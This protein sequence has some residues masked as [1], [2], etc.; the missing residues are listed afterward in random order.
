[1]K[2]TGIVFIALFVISVALTWPRYQFYRVTGKWFPVDKIEKLSSPILVKAYSE[3]GIQVA[4]G[5]TIQLPDFRKLPSSS[6]AL[7][8]A[9][10]RGIE[11][12]TDGRVYCLM[13]IVHWCGNDPVR[14][15]I[16]RLD[17]S[18]FM[19]FAGEGEREMPVD[20]ADKEFF[21]ESFQGE[22]DDRDLWVIEKFGKARKQIN[23]L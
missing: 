18:D 3:D 21:P 12:G 8:K 23:R 2:L 10:E 1:M 13:K 9:T 5:R 16:A 19:T 15:H 11:V 14:E 20:E 7:T 17:L 4:D 22:L 6:S